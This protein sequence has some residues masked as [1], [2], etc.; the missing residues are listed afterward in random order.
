MINVLSV[1]SELNFGGG[2]NRLLN[3]ARTIDSNRFRL[4]VATLYSREHPLQSQCGSMQ[5]QF[6]EAG[7][8]VHAIGL[9]HPSTVQGLRVVKLAGTA[10]TLATAVARL[11]QLIISTR[12]QIVDAHLETA[13]YTAVPAAASAGSSPG[14]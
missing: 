3:F 2:E 6:A 9:P 12:A 5:G 11:R 8:K 14:P 7:V 4:T 1:I 10:T 13:L